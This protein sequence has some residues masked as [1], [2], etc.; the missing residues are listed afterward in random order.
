MHMHNYYYYFKK[1]YY[2]YS[3]CSAESGGK[4]F[5]SVLRRQRIEIESIGKET[6]DESTKCQAIRP[7]AREILDFYVLM[8][9]DIILQDFIKNYF[10][11]NRI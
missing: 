10:L 7:T 6:M 4:I 3:L 9:I 8:M 11:G 2:Y 1:N 5:S